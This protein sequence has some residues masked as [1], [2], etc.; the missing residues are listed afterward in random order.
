M[1]EWNIQSR[2]HRCQACGKSFADKQVYHT[3]LFD[4]KQE[5]KRLDICSGCWQSQYSQGASDRK[6][7][8]SYWQGVYEAPPAAPEPIQ[9]ENAESLL[10]KLI[11]LNDPRH[12]AAAYILAVMLERKRLLKVKEQLV[13]DAQR[14]FIYEQP[15]TGDLFTIPDPNLQLNQLDEVQRDVAALLEHG[16]N[17]P[18][19]G[20]TIPA[21][22]AE[23]PGAQALHDGSGE[24]SAGPPPENAFTA[25]NEP[26]VR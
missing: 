12:S 21:A 26:L 4:E 23:G 8:V 1:N 5:F 6:G 15:R 9:K 24:I 2:A 10:R 25:A 17:P 19:T 14:I 22:S 11:E 16:L 13:R 7:F 3:L 20:T 18:A